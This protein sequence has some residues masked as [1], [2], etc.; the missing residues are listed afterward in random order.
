MTYSHRVRMNF[1]IRLNFIILQEK[2]DISSE[3]ERDDMHRLLMNSRE[4]ANI[5]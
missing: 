1:I 5:R 2:E 4:K 3:N